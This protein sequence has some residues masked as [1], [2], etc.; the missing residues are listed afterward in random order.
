LEKYGPPFQRLIFIN[1]KEKSVSKQRKKMIP[2][3]Y[4]EVF[5][6]TYLLLKVSDLAPCKIDYSC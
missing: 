4:G 2:D 3:A 6:S 1:K 5:K